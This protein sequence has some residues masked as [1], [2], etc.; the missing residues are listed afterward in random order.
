[1]IRL[2]ANLI[3]ALASLLLVV[4]LYSPARFVGTF[5]VFGSAVNSPLHGWLG[6]TPRG[7]K[8]VVDVGKVNSWQC[9]D[10]SIFKQHK[11]GCRLWLRVF[12][13]V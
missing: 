2:R 6:P 12:G 10:I 3:G 8:C 1:M 4:L 9:P 7:S 11:Y 13:Y 5:E